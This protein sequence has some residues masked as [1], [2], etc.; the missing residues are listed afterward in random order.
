MEPSQLVVL[1]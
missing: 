1:Y